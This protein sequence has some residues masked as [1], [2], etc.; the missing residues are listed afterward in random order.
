[1]K[2]LLL[3]AVSMLLALV[4]RPG[5]AMAGPTVGVVATG[6]PTLQPALASQLETWLRG[7]GYS[8]MERALDAGAINRIIDCFTI[9]DSSCA[10]KVVEKAAKSDSV[11][12]ARAA[13]EG[14]TVSLSLYWILKGKPPVGVR[15]GCEEC[16]E[17]ALRGLADELMT[18]LAPAAAASSGRLKLTT[19]P[20]G[21]IVMLDGAKIG[22][23]PLERD[24]ASGEHT[25]VIVDGGTRVGERRV[26]ILAGATIEVTMTPEYPRNDLRRPPPPPGPSRAVPIL[27]ITGGVL[28]LGGGGFGLYLGQKGGPDHP[29]DPYIYKGATPAG[30]AG[31]SVG[32]VAIGVGIWQWRRASRGRPPRESSPVAVISSHGSYFGWQG[33]F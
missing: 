8:I 16:S 15:R 27:L 33:K 32:A 22:V 23:T 25:L 30:I 2:P 21:L 28:A 26:K 19:K 17:G 7:H 24:I 12:Y 5:D 31:I 9:D 14:A 10:R 6:E 4:G 29:E 11:V 20:D 3:V 13:R 1:M 18:G